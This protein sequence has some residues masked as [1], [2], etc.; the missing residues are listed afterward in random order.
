MIFGALLV[1]VS[2]RVRLGISAFLLVGTEIVI[3]FFA[4]EVLQFTPY[5]QLLLLPGGTNFLT[6]FIRSCLGWV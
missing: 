3:R 6:C 5:T 2:P 4:A 1:S